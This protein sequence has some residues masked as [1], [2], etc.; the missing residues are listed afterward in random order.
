MDPPPPPPTR[1]GHDYRQ[2]LVGKWNFEQH[3][4]F[5]LPFSKGEHLHVFLIILP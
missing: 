3:E 5:E 1:R 4:P 2:V